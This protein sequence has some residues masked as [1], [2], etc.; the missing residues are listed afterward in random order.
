MQLTKSNNRMLAGV[1]SG[2]AEW[3][4]WSAGSIRALFVMVSILFLGIGGVVLYTILA[5]AMPPPHNFNI[6]DF[7]A[8]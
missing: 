8:Q 2:I 6:D 1:C 3:V 5:W 7:R 4:G